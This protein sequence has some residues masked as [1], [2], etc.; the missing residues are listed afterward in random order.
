MDDKKQILLEERMEGLASLDASPNGE[1]VA[2]LIALYESS[3]K[4]GLA[5]LK[6]YIA[7]GD[8]RVPKQAHSLKSSSA[9]LGLERVT[10]IFQEIENFHYTGEC[11]KKAMIQL[12]EEFKLGIE[13]LHSFY[14]QKYAKTIK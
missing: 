11:L 13:A 14:N 10:Y 7:E 1:L 4:D 6:T 2:K 8:A 3:T 12:D 5:L 9:N